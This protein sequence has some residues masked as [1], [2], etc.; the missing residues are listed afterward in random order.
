MIESIELKAREL[1]NRLLDALRSNEDGQTTAEYVAVTAVGVSLAIVIVWA[2]MGSAI[3]TAVG[4]IAT[5]LTN[6]V[7]SPPVIT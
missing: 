5:A 6:F 4:D 2:V 3:T 1:L 7:S